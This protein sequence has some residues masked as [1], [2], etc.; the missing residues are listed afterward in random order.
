MKG[1]YTDHFGAT[2][3]RARTG[4]VEALPHHDGALSRQTHA[5]REQRITG[6][7]IALRQTLPLVRE[8]KEKKKP[9]SP[10]HSVSVAPFFPSN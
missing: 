4:V 9:P 5:R 8:G 7:H 1:S 3:S 2:Q 10:L 6:I